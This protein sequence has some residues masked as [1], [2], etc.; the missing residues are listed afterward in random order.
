M[1]AVFLW[2]RTKSDPQAALAS[3]RS[4][5]QSLDPALQLQRVQTV[6]Q[7]LDQ[8]L[9]APR[10]GAELLGGFGLLA[11]VLAAIGTYGVM[12]YGVSQ[13]TQEIGIRMALGAQRTDVLRLIVSGGMAMVT[14]G[15]IAGL[16]LATVLARSMS[17]LLYGIGMFDAASFFSTAALLIAVALGACM[18]PARRAAK[19]DPMVALRYE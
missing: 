13:R 17:T 15:V 7:D 11:L 2:V 3:I 12:S 9:A 10:L 19:V 1:P 16:A 5:V 14:V 8:S 4:T 18:I 6:S